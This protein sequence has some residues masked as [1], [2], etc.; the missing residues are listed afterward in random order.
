MKKIRVADYIAEFIVQKGVRDFFLLPGGGAMYLVDALGN[1]KEL[2]FI[3]M[4]N[5]QSVTIA[6]ES[7]SRVSENFGVALVT[8]GP[9]AT[10]AITGAVGA[11][12]ESVPMMV[13]SGQVKRDDLIG[14]RKIRQGGVQEVDIVS[15]VKNHTK[16]AITVKDP[17]KIKYYLQKAYH[18]M[19]EGRKGP[20]WI[21]VP[22]DVQGAMID[23]TELL[24]YDEPKRDENKIEIDK[25]KKLI[26]LINNSGRPLILAGH[27]IRLSGGAKEFKRFIEQFKIPIVATWNAMDL[28]EH[29]NEFFVGKPGVVAMRSA[30]FAIQNCD[31]LISIG[32]RLDNIIT[33][34]NP[35]RFAKNAKKVMVDID[36]NEIENSQID[37]EMSFECDAKD[38]IEL[39]QSNFNYV[40][41]VDRQGWIQKCNYWKNRYTLDYEF[42]FSKNEK[43][44]HF[45]FANIL[46]T[47]LEGGELI[48]TGSSGL[49][50]EA[51]Y[52][53]FNIKKGQRIYLTSGLGAM[54][55]GLPSAIGACVAN[56]KEKI[57]AIES[58]GS[59]QLNI[60]ELATLKGQNLPILLFVMD[61]SGYAS[62]RNTQKNYFDGRYVA[63]GKEGSLHMPNIAKVCDGYEI[64]NITVNDEKE[65]KDAIKIYDNIK[66][67]FVVIVKLLENE[68]LYPKSMAMPQS[69]GSMVSMPLEDMSPL[70]PI[71]ELKG[72]MTFE[73]DEVSYRVRDVKHR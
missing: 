31:L 32:S 68:T 51:L 18:E 66:K 27:G 65:L 38:F 5:E 67:P 21:D 52:V 24:G 56:N 62:I 20:V 39:L 17:K 72:E 47:E 30:N 44:S 46:S 34:Y 60:Q 28:I 7:Y 22:L 35:K 49:G 36:K 33:A 61:N 48:S 14:T 8:T 63:T 59:L 64:D 41:D 2:N 45:Q 73:L 4:H 15:M 58:D 3:A 19:M 1:H 29:D 11:W 25:I 6:T 12:I 42:D 16:Y 53:A 54:G 50:L 23:P 69:D 26:S 9:G 57:V 71:E 13:I 37:F 70:L 55:Y 10:N 43:M 40:E